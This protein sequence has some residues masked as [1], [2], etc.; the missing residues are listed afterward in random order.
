MVNRLT[1]DDFV[2]KEDILNLIAWSDP[3]SMGPSLIA[4]IMNKRQEDL[5]NALNEG[6]ASGALIDITRGYR[7]NSDLLEKQ[8]T[9]FPISDRKEW[10]INVCRRMGD[11]F[12]AR[13]KDSEAM[14]EFDAELPLLPKW[15]THVKPYSIY[16][17]SRLTWLQ[18]YPLYYQG[19]YE[20]ALQ[21]VQKAMS[22][23][24]EAQTPGAEAEDFFKLK[25]NLFQDIAAITDELGNP[26][27]ALTYYQ[28]ALEILEQHL[29]RLKAE[30]AEI[31]SNIGGVHDRAGNLEEAIKHF[32]Q[33][34]EIRQQ[35]FGDL[36][37]DTATSFNNIGA[38]FHEAKKYS[39]AIQY[40]QKAM[41]TRQQL[42]GD[43]H[44]DTNDSLYN[45]AVCL[46][47]VK[48]LKEAYEWV[49][50]QLKKLSPDHSNYGEL[51]GLLQYIDSESVKS[52]FRPMSAG[53]MGKKGKKKK[54]KR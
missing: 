41:E 16:H 25:A 17:M 1:N 36:H 29:H 21:L 52:G 39:E 8:K 9:Q 37:P 40:L 42:L 4:A 14:A 3:A 31:I 49:H 30:K 11:W 48:K 5:Q 6:I 19:K 12:D 28:Q 34:L 45:L 26:G 15:L 27:E 10:V 20:D 47:N 13:R 7:L 23:L 22:G 35:L 33:A 2:L 43:E 54:K 44:P 46:V 50:R 32:E 24:D 51:A 53:S 18:A 38:C